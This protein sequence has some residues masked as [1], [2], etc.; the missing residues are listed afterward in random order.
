[1]SCSR[2]AVTERDG[3]NVARVVIAPTGPKKVFGSIQR[4]AA[5]TAPASTLKIARN[6]MNHQNSDLLARPEKLAYLAKPALIALVKFI[7]PSFGSFAWRCVSMEPDGLV[8]GLVQ[9]EGSQPMLATEP[10]EK[11]PLH[12]EAGQEG[13]NQPV[14]LEQDQRKRHPAPPE[15]TTRSSQAQTCQDKISYRHPLVGDVP[16]RGVDA[17][18]GNAQDHGIDDQKLQFRGQVHVIATGKVEWFAASVPN[19]LAG[20]RRS[21]QSGRG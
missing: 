15:Q 8:S 9:I 14:R 20:R 3:R 2:R 13:E 6:S 4:N 19:L 7:I 17:P 10:V 1:M 12:C 11:G 5:S 21:G 18:I 16:E